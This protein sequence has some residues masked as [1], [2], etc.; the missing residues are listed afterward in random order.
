VPT[1]AN[2]FPTTAAGWTNFNNVKVDDGSVAT[3][4]NAS[5]LWNGSAFVDTTS[6]S[7]LV[8]GFTG[9]DTGIIDSDQIDGLEVEMQIGYSSVEAD[10]ITVYLCYNGTPISFVTPKTYVLTGTGAGLQTLTFGGPADTWGIY[11][12]FKFHIS[13]LQVLVIVAKTVA[14]GTAVMECDYIKATATYTE[15]RPVGSAPITDLSGLEKAS[16]HYSDII[17]I[18]GI[19]P[20]ASSQISFEYDGNYTW[21]ANVG[22]FGWTAFG[23]STIYVASVEDGDTFQLFAYA[24]DGY[25]TQSNIDIEFGVGYGTDQWRLTTRAQITTITL[26]QFTDVA[27]AAASSF[28]YSGMVSLSGFDTDYYPTFAAAGWTWLYRDAGGVGVWADITASP[29]ATVGYGDRFY[30]Y[31]Q[32]SATAGASVA[33]TITVDGNVRQFDVTTSTDAYPDPWGWIPNL[34]PHAPGTV[35][36]SNVATITGMLGSQSITLYGWGNANTFEVSKN[37]GVWTAM[38]Y[39]GSCVQGDTFSVRCTTGA[40]ANDVGGISAY[41]NGTTGVWAADFIV[42]NGAGDPVPT[43]FTMTDVQTAL[44]NTLQYSNVVTAAGLGVT[45]PLNF[46]QHGTETNTEVS[47]NAGAWS[48]VAGGYYLG[49]GDTFQLRSKS[50]VVP[51]GLKHIKVNFGTLTDT[52][53]IRTRNMPPPPAF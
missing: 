44:P 39:G 30:G 12:L 20:G 41:V 49:N 24:E 46:D 17:T 16:G 31:A 15:I 28:Q 25:S 29:P 13:N 52:F 50:S 3:D 8:G 53:T 4:G 9:L 45:T 5:H 43:A 51:Q 7:L 48:T 2:I 36:T 40:G 1:N 26:G 11:G 34:G 19:G 33:A 32:A 42:A 27:A 10:L 22:T 18:S 37:F 6:A 23:P 38:P 21:Y 47:I 35:C 14:A